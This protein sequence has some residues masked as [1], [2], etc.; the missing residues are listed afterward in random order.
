MATEILLAPTGTGKTEQA[1]ARLRVLHDQQPFA[2]VWVLTAT[3]RQREAMRQRL[4]EARQAANQQHVYFNIEFFNFY[5]LYARILH[6]YRVPVL[7]LDDAARFRLL[8]LILGQMHTDGHLQ[9]FGKIWRTNGFISAVSDL[10]S[11]LKQKI[12]SPE[13]FTKNKRDHR[14]D[15]EIDDIYSRYQKLLQGNGLV[16]QEGE[17]W[18]ALAVLRENPQKINNLDLLLVDG[19]DQFSTLQASLVAELAGQAGNALITLTTVPQREKTIG[20]RFEVAK[21]ILLD[22]HKNLLDPHITILNQPE[23]NADPRPATLQ[24]FHNTIFKEGVHNITGD[25]HVQFIEAA[26]PEQ[27]VAAV[28]RR[29]KALIVHEH[30]DAET[31]LVA[32][33]DWELYAA[34]FRTY[35]RIYQLPLSLHYGDRLPRNSAMMA[36]TDLLNL[37]MEDFPTSSLFDVLRSPYFTIGTLTEQQISWLEWVSREKLVLGGR[38]VWLE[39]LEALANAIAPTHADDE[40]E[41]MQPFGVAEA[42]ALLAGLTQFFEAVTPKPHATIKQYVEWLETLIGPDPNRDSND[43]PAEEDLSSR[44]HLLR[45][46]RKQNIAQYVQARDLKAMQSF[47]RVLRVLLST[48]QIIIQLQ[49]VT[50]TPWADFYS[51]LLGTAEIAHIEKSPERHGQVLVTLATDA[52]GLPHQ[53]VFVVGMS[54]GIFPMMPSEDPLYLDSEREELTRRGIPL[55]TRQE[56]ATD[57]GLFYEL[58][59]L[60]QVSLTLSRPYSKQG[61]KWIESHLWR[62][63]LRMFANPDAILTRIPM[64]GIVPL[65]QACALDE[66]T[67][68]AMHGNSHN[69]AGVAATVAWLEQHNSGIWQHILAAQKTETERMSRKPHNQYSGRL[70]DNALVEQ[71][72][73]KLGPNRV[74]SA[75][76]LNDLGQCGFRFFAKQLLKLEA[77]EAPEE[78]LDVLTLGTLYHE[79]LEHTYRRIQ[80]EQLTIDE[81]N[82]P[83][84]IAILQE[85]AI[86]CFADAPQRLGFRATA[87]WRQE[88]QVQLRRLQALIEVDFSDQS[89]LGKRAMM[90]QRRP[91]LLE[92]PFGGQNDITLLQLPNGENIRVRGV[93]DRIDQIE[94]PDGQRGALVVD[95]KSGSSTISTEEMTRGRNF[96]MPLYMRVLPTILA[97]MTDAP[98]NVWAGLFWHIS[99]R[100]PS[101]EVE[102]TNDAVE[103]AFERLTDQLLAAREGDFN[104]TPKKYEEGKCSRYCEYAK[105]CRIAIMGRSKPS[106]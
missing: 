80:Q 93:I 46:V 28:V 26:T 76:Q 99:S 103:A 106:R 65:E 9:V 72:A 41:V 56:R 12:I 1:L 100:K 74:W 84:A 17:G 63:S 62:K 91:L 71:V 89:P 68:A 5:E 29:I 31:I 14:K 75:S 42:Q 19:Y 97:Q 88:Q 86:A 66:L 10:V 81:A 2:R 67:L 43:D 77:L 7:R 105:M 49:G 57:E 25:A 87:L 37:H 98:S 90:G 79:V 40:I 73:R 39:T 34:H 85:E 15:H 64:E 53:H 6:L 21:Q 35:Q 69:K 38:T 11:E 32:V 30:A 54:E 61:Q 51:E 92:A 27:E 18:L 94:L 60:A 20:R 104:S 82:R 8:R 95:Y 96:Q 50:E 55:A 52:R 44:F 70:I 16:D 101:G 24:S 36:L 33:R 48:E 102:P 22:A 45:N 13:L 4:S 47:K 23:A 83:R 78:G 3:A 59:G 58:I